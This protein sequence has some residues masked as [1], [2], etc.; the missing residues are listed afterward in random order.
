MWA[1][2]KSVGLKVLAHFWNP[3]ALAAGYA[4]GKMDALAWLPG[5]LSALSGLWN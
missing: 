4:A 3:L 5:A 2:I 1:T